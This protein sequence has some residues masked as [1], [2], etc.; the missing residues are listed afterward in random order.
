VSTSTIEAEYVVLSIATKHFLWLKTE[1]SDLRFPETSMAL[2]CDNFSV[3][4]LAENYWISE[5]SKP[6]NIH[7]QHIRKLVYNKTPLLIYIHTTDNLADICTKGLPE[8]QLSKLG[9]IAL[10]Y[11]EERY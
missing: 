2:F 3:I 4:D 5:L 8:V 6:C 7:H 10:G 9:T 1:L 11:N